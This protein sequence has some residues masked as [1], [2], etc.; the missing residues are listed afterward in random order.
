ML[1]IRV[2][3]SPSG[4]MVSDIEQCMDTLA[5]IRK[6]P[7]APISKQSSRVSQTSSQN[8][9]VKVESEKRKMSSSEDEDEIA[10]LYQKRK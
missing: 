4:N 3:I 7:S 2:G 6:L 5:T 10:Q 9:R 8:I 1:C